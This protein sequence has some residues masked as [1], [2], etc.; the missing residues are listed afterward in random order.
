MNL[1]CEYLHRLCAFGDGE[2][3][4]TIELRYLYP[5]HF[6][7]GHLFL[8]VKIILFYFIFILCVCVFCLH[9][10]FCTNYVPCLR[11]AREGIICPGT[12]ITVM[13]WKPNRDLLEA[14]CASLLFS[15]LVLGEAVNRTLLSQ[16][17][18]SF[19]LR[20]ASSSPYS[21]CLFLFPIRRHRKHGHL[22]R[23]MPRQLCCL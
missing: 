4:K 16:V 19:L 23:Q 22:T 21:P 1:E 13:C 2:E 9:A 20:L 6:L 18:L 11:R 15:K 3:R 17:S 10:S 14:T 5:S 12:G 8:F 7:V